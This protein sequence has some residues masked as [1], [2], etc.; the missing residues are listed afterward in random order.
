MKTFGYSYADVDVA[1]PQQ[2]FD[3]KYGWSIRWNRGDSFGKCPTDMLPF[4]MTKAQIYQFSPSDLQ[5]AKPGIIKAAAHAAHS[6]MPAGLL[7]GASLAQPLAQA[8]ASVAQTATTSGSTST[9]G[10]SGAGSGSG[11]SKCGAC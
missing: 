11:E 7:S 4:D 8:A 3:N 9:S 10:T 2:N 6:I 5:Q 1:N